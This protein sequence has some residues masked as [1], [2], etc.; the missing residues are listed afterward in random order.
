MTLNK[1]I[2]GGQS[3]PDQAA[4]KCARAHGIPTGGTACKGWLTENGPAPWLAEYGLVEC[5]RAG[6][7]PRTRQNA[8]D[9][10]LTAIFDKGLPNMLLNAAPDRYKASRGTN[11]AVN[12]ARG[13]GKDFWINPTAEDL[14]RYVSAREDVTVNVGGN[15]AS[16]WPGGY[17]YVYG[18]LSEFFRLL[19]RGNYEL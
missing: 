4:L 10:G 7:P 14:A 19:K 5:K 9:A 8:Q 13:W 17:D 12:T 11:L 6:Y 1:I 16:K 2:S 18:V 3:G 15:R